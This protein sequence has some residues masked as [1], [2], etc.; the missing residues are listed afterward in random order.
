MKPFNPDEYLASKASFDPDAYLSSKTQPQA[1]PDVSMLESGVR[2]A[3]QGATLGFADEL[4][5]ALE[6]AAGSLGL[7][8]DKTYEQARDEARAAY[9]AAE[10]AN[11]GTYL[12][13][14]IAGG[15]GSAVLA[16]GAAASTA[17]RIA[18][19]A[20]MG[21][22]AGYGSSNDRDAALADM[23]RGAIVGGAVGAAGEGISKAIPAIG[24]WLG[25][26][27]ENL[28]VKA[29]GATGKEAAA[30]KPGT[31]RAILENP[32][33]RAWDSATGIA[34]KTGEQLESTG[35][36]LSSLLKGLDESG[37][38][39]STE[40]LAN[41]LAQRADELAQGPTAPL[42][43]QIM[44]LVDEI[45]N[46]APSS[47]TGLQLG[48]NG[49]VML[50]PSQVESWKRSYGD[51]IKNWVDPTSGVANKEA[52]DVM[53]NA[54]EK[55]AQEA[56]GD[57]ASAF[58][59]AKNE[60]GTF[61]PV[62]EAAARRSGTL[63]QSPFG[64]LL[65]VQRAQLG[66]Q[67]AGAEGATAL[68]FVMKLLAPRL[69]NLTAHSTDFVSKLMKTPPAALGKFASTIQNAA[70]RGQNAVAVTDWL[71][72]Q[73]NPEYRQMKKNLP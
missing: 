22:V 31:G 72:E 8:P 6:S 46:T 4:T 48:E 37:A 44:G 11:P 60:Y 64:G 18:Q 27:A 38:A 69:V 3:A 59:A 42:S 1:A 63:N 17:G 15:I 47:R 20:G 67:I 5:G 45:R 52:Y 26:R 57:V 24:N 12:A 28:A 51:L 50:K 14:N 49:Q 56:G 66:Q 7:V 32:N 30:F 54:T 68:P 53:K 40:D 35:E 62:H 61:M 43:R 65:D 39:I 13:G 10:Q 36:K 19:A 71:L 70:T 73:S 55:F 9:Q 16:P 25:N 29:T 34:R 23:A 2:G 21:A 41:Q 33:I 58:Q